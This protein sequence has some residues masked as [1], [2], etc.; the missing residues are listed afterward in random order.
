MRKFLIQIDGQNKSGSCKYFIFRQT[1]GLAGA[2]REP[3]P[4][5]DGNHKPYGEAPGA[6]FGPIE[7]FQRTAFITQRPTKNLPDL[8]DATA[9]EKKSLFV[10]LAGIDYLQGFADAAAEKVKHEAA[11]AHDAKIKARVLQAGIDKKPEEEKTLKETETALATKKAELAEVTKQ[12][13]AMKADME[14]LQLAWSAEQVRRGKENEAKAAVNTAGTEIRNLSLGID[15][16][17]GAAGNKPRYEKEA[18]EY[19]AQQKV[20]NAETAKKQAH[21]ESNLKTQQDYAA[22]KSDYDER[23]KGLEF[24][25]DKLCGQRNAIERLAAEAES[26]IRFAIKDDEVERNRL[27]KTLADR[28]AKVERG[29][30]TAKNRIELCERDAAEI[31]ED[32]PASH[33]PARCEDCQGKG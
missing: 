25:R 20:I 11:K 24:E 15:T 1:A 2:G 29:I 10:A 18:A 19:E 21:N 22:A 4:G 27:C 9:G 13:K 16:L 5:A 6:A 17:T 3:R 26:N 28:K 7:L 23:L 31:T 32:C 8:T 33:R 12:G 30:L 14:R